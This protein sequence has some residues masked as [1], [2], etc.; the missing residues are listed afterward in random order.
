[1]IIAMEDYKKIRHMFLVEGKSQRQ[2]A[3]TLGI[4]RN[5]VAKYCNS[6]IY[7]GI[8]ADY[9]WLFLYETVPKNK[10][11]QPYKAMKDESISFL[12]PELKEYIDNM[13]T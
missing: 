12:S 10:L 13:G 8:R 4:S 9:H 1:V 7:P 3:R 2:I 11:N 6:N 5:T